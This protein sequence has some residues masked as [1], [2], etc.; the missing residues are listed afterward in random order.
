MSSLFEVLKAAKGLPVSNSFYARWGKMLSRSGEAGVYKGSLPATIQTD[1]T[2]LTDYRIYGAAGGVGQGVSYNILPPGEAATVSTEDGKCSVTSDGHGHY[3]WSYAK[4][5][6]TTLIKIPLTVTNVVIPR[7]MNY[8]VSG[9]TGAIYVGNSAATDSNMQ[10]RFYSAS[11]SILG[12]NMFTSIPQNGI[13]TNYDMDSEPC[14]AI[15]FYVS[16]SHGAF[17]LDLNIMVT[18]DSVKAA[19]PFIEY[20]ASGYKLTV[21]SQSSGGSTSS[22]DLYIGSTPLQ[23]GEY[24]S[25]ADQAR[26]NSDETVTPLVLPSI[27]TYSGTTVIDCTSSP[28]PEKVRLTI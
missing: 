17:E 28:K 3:H 2:A 7:G 11:D 12:S 20:G 5:S 6:N 16:N 13:L 24:L 23:S 18:S 21:T 25:Y 9:G 14:A 8:R 26:Y 27:P 15:G 1:G 10:L 19:R 4:R 22:A